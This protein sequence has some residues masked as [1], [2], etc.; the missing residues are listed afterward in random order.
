[1]KL[2][3]YVH[4]KGCAIEETN[5][6]LDDIHE[7]RAPR[8]EIFAP[9]GKQFDGGVHSLLCLNAEDVRER[10]ETYP[11]TD[12]PEDCDCKTGAQE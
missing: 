11:L 4:S 3:D 1:M 8:Y 9:V 10:L 12:C 6:S 5:D 2:V 7:G